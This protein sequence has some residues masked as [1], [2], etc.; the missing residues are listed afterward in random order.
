MRNSTRIPRSGGPSRQ[1]LLKIAG[2]RRGPRPTAP[3]VALRAVVGANL[4]GPAEQQ[5]HVL[6]GD[7]NGRLRLHEQ[8]RRRAPAGPLVTAL[9]ERVVDPGGRAVLRVL[10]DRRELPVG[11]AEDRLLEAQ[12]RQRAGHAEQ[13]REV[14]V[15]LLL[16][17]RG[18][19]ELVAL[20]EAG[21]AG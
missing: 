5:L 8:R 16:P 10:R 19:D 7:P 2:P 12:H 20:R 11:G 4:L 13:A 3:A 14:L 17:A 9:V 21:Q 6:V 15:R 18:P 1:G